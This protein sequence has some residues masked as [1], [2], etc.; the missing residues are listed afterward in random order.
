MVANALALWSGKSGAGTSS[1]D[2]LPELSVRDLS[3]AEQRA[4]VDAKKRKNADGGF[5]GTAS[6]SDIGAGGINKLDLMSLLKEQQ[7]SS[8]IATKQFLPTALSEFT[9]KPI[10]RNSTVLATFGEG[11]KEQFETV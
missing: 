3:S 7:D 5:V 11:I 4:L 1:G 10:E 8:A 6:H 2:A 9:E